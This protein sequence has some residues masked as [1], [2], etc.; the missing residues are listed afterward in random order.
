M[1][2]SLFAILG[3][4]R[5]QTIWPWIASS[6]RLSTVSAPDSSSERRMLAT[7]FDSDC[8]FN[9]F[10]SHENQITAAAGA[11]EF[12][13]ARDVAMYLN[14]ITDAVVD[15]VRKHRDLRFEGRRE[16]LA[17]RSGVFFRDRLPA[18]VGGIGKSLRIGRCD[19]RIR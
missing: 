16:S 1:V 9:W 4:L 3:A 5:V 19:G 15:H 14:Q 6:M 8:V 2:G 17:K 7:D 18:G 11:T 13:A 10:V 12:P